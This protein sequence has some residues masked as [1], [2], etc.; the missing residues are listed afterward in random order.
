MGATVLITALIGEEDMTEALALLRQWA[1]VRMSAYGRAL[2]EEEL[3]SELRGVEAVLGGG[4]P[5]TARVIEA[6]DCLRIIARDGV[7]LDRVDLQAATKKGVVVTITPTICESVAD[8]TFGLI[9]CLLRKVTTADRLVREGEWPHRAKFVSKEVNGSTL[10]IVGLGRV[11]SFVA[12]RAAA[13]NMEVIAFDPYVDAGK[14]ASVGVELADLDTVLQKSDTV[15]IH[16]PLT[17][18]TRGLLGQRQLSLMKTGAFLVNAARGAIVDEEAL[19]EA[20]RSRRLGGAALDVLSVEPPSPDN[21]L[22]KMENVI[23]TPHMGNDT[24][25]AFRRLAIDAARDIIS[26]LK[27]EMPRYAVNPE[28]L[29]RRGAC[30]EGSL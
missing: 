17:E 19:I 23:L 15:T 6:T 1:T 4:D 10:G 13:F 29:T 25:E 16:A 28:A 20:L 2:T 12:R 5:Y 18:E 11:G 27:G 24:H 7:G 9:I 26:A 14:A 8:L 21:P 30:S 22:L 3:L